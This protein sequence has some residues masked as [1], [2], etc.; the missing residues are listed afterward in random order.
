MWYPAEF[1]GAGENN[2]RAICYMTRVQME[3][4]GNHVVHEGGWWFSM[5]EWSFL[6]PW[7]KSRGFMFFLNG[8]RSVLMPWNRPV[9]L[10]CFIKCDNPYEFC[11]FSD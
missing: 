4:Q 6:A 7:P 8:N 5:V 9:G 10:W 3:P 2:K 11:V 1:M